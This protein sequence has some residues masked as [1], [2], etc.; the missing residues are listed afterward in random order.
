VSSIAKQGPEQNKYV[1]SIGYVP[2][3]SRDNRRP[4]DAADFL[5]C[6]AKQPYIFMHGREGGIHLFEGCPRNA[7][8]RIEVLDRADQHNFMDPERDLVELPIPR[9]RIG[10]GESWAMRVVRSQWTNCCNLSHCDPV[11]HQSLPSSMAAVA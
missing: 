11:P 6:Q 10:S 4:L 7:P 1:R 5:Q 2:R 8:A 9:I 3:G